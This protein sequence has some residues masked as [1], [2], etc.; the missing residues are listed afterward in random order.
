MCIPGEEKIMT[1]ASPRLSCQPCDDVTRGSSR[2]ALALIAIVTNSAYQAI[3]P[4]LP[5]EMNRHALSES[6]IPFVF[7]AFSI[8]SL[9]TP[10]F[11][12]HQFDIFGTAKIMAYS[13]V[14]MSIAFACLGHVFQIAVS[15]LSSSSSSSE[16][17]DSSIDQQ[18]QQNNIGVLLLLTVAEFFL[19]FFYSI[20]ASGYYGLATSGPNKEAAMS[21][22]EIAVGIGYVIGPNLASYLYN[23]RGYQITYYTISAIMLGMAIVTLTCLVPHLQ[24]YESNTLIVVENDELVLMLDDTEEV[25][26]QQQK[27]SDGI[28]NYNSFDGLVREECHAMIDRQ[29][30]ENSAN[31]SMTTTA[32]TTPQPTAHSLLKFPKIILGLLSICWIK[33][34]F[35][36]VEP[37]LTLRL[38]KHFHIRLSHIGMIFSLANIVYV[39]AVYLSQYLPRHGNEQ[40][41]TI[42]IS[43]M[44]TP[45]GVYLLGSDSLS[46]LI[47]AVTLC[48]ILQAP[49]WVHLLP[50]MQEEAFKLH[51]VLE[52]R[53]LVNDITSS[54]YNS[55]NTLGQ[56]VG[57]IIDLLMTSHGFA[58]MTHM[59][60]LLVFIQGAIFYMQDS[61]L[62]LWRKMR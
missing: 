12:A 8:G 51:P 46:V 54:I 31:I 11:I 41:R 2:L 36:F 18:Q 56:A 47:V 5:L 1:A 4:I 61:I 20:I 33:A 43:I 6:Y 23:V 35:A 37:L 38:E 13:M 26:Q 22:I 55:S 40:C 62:I 21:S 50:W 29:M 39:P 3:A 10:P 44:L 49:V 34:S 16:N 42:A 25:Q 45:M 60:A 59:V 24:Y 53:Q 15:S 7:I 58:Q 19:G 52:H 30:D 27:L 17:D 57:Y 9:I 14:G 48:G 28:Q 32:S